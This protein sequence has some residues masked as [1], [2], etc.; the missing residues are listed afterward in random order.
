MIRLQA[1]L[2]RNIQLKLTFLVL[3]LSSFLLTA[4][5]GQATP[6]PNGPWETQFVLQVEDADLTQATRLILG[7]LADELPDHL[8]LESGYPPAGWVFSRANPNDPDIV[9]MTCHP[10][11]ANPN[12][13]Q[14][15]ILLNDAGDFIEVSPIDYLSARFYMFEVYVLDPASSAQPDPATTPRVIINPHQWSDDDMLA[16]LLGAIS[17]ALRNLGAE[18]IS[19]ES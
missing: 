10:D 4:C 1:K 16:D 14:R 5:A 18:P 2:F 9:D 3:L 15:C 7:A 8:S 19:F 11:E 13:Q 12:S 17:A 6:D